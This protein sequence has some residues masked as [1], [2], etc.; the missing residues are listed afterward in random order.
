M[1]YECLKMQMDVW[2]QSVAYRMLEE[3][4]AWHVNPLSYYLFFLFLAYGNW[5]GKKNSWCEYFI[6]DKRQNRQK[7]LLLKKKKK[8]I[9]LS[10]TNPV[11]A[12]WLIIVM[13]S[14]RANHTVLAHWDR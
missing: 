14:S 6:I 2:A 3:I 11:L 5:R 13:R 8:N 1:T 7:D 4:Q 10:R 12:T 9:L